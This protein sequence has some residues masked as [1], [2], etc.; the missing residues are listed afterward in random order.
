MSSN[1]VSFPR[2][3]A[4]AELD[5]ERNE[6]AHTWKRFISLLLPQDQVQWE[7]RPQTVLDV[8]TLLGNIKTF[9]MSRP[10]PRVFSDSMDLC[11]RLL[12][13]VDTHANL[14]S[15]L[16]DHMAYSPLFYGVVQS[17]IKVRGPFIHTCLL[18]FANV[19]VRR[20][21]IIHG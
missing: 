2:T 5:I 3:P 20:R 21:H 19:R 11:D 14:I 13:T 10:R 17:V 9:W 7:E 1:P 8:K 4:I 12:P 6:L 18:P 15:T 16:P